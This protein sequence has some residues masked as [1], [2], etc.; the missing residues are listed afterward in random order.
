MV[1]LHITGSGVNPPGGNGSTNTGSTN[2]GSTSTGSTNT[3]NT[4]TG[5][6]IPPATTP[7]SGGGGYSPSPIVPVSVP[8]QVGTM[9]G[10]N[11]LGGSVVG[12][13]V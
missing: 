2:T 10:V 1:T 3:G 6:I 13:L 8:V 11:M 9:S 7:S 4:N 12:T 5:T